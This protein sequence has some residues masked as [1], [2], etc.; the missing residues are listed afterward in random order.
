[1]YRKLTLLL[2]ALV[3]LTLQAQEYRSASNTYYW[4]NRK[5]YEGYWQQ[6]VHYRIKASLNDSTDII[7]GQQQLTYWN[8]SP[9]ELPFVYFRLTQNAFQPDSYLDDLQKNNKVKPK[10]GVYE[11]MRLGTTIESLMV[12]GKVLRT[13]LDNTIL[14]VYLD[15]PLRSGESITFDITFKTYFDKGNTRRRMKLFNSYGYKHYD[16]V[17]WYP[18]ISVYD[19]KFG[20]TTDQHLGRE[21]YG[22]FG[23]FDVE[24]TLPNH[25]VLDATGVLQ[26]RSEVM[27]DSLRQKLDIKNFAKKPLYERPS[28]IIKR[29]GTRKTWKFYADNVHDFAFTADPTYRIGETEWNGIKC[30]S[31][32]QEPHA[33][34]WQ[35]AADYTARILKVY[36]EDIG[37]YAY[38][39]M[40][41]ADAQDGM[42][43]PMLTLDGGF[44][45]GYRSLLAHEVGH[46]WFFGMVGNNETYRAALDEG[47]TQFLT[48]WCMEKLEGPYEPVVTDTTFF[49]W[50]INR[51]SKV[52]PIRERRAYL[53]YLNDAVKDLDMP[54]NTHS[55]QFNGALEHGGGYRHVYYK[56]A[57]MLYNLQYVLGDELFLK[58]MQHYFNQWKMCHPYFE[59][60]R[61][62]IIQYTHV[63]LNWFFDQW[64]E[65]TKH[66]DYRVKSVRKGTKDG[67]FVITFERKGDMQMPLDFQVIDDKDRRHEFHIPNDWFVKKT[68]A[69][70]LPRWIGWGSVQPEYQATV[71]IPEGIENVVIDTTYRLA[72]VNMLNNSRRTPYTLSFDS[73]MVNSP[74][75]TQ[76]EFK[77]RPDIWY[78]SYDGIKAGVHVNGGYMN[79]KHVFSATL[80]FNT[81]LAQ[82]YLSPEVRVNRFDN[83]SYNLT[84]SNGIHEL[85]RNTFLKL[86]AR[87]L[88]GLNAYTAGITKSDLSQKNTL[89]VYFKSMYRQDS[90]DLVYLLY[91]REWIPG[92]YNNTINVGVERKYNYR[93]GNGII[94]LGLKSS[95]LGSSYDYARISLTVVNRNTLGKFDLHTRT[96]A[97]YGTGRFLPRESAL[98]LA[99]GNPEDLMENK[100]TRSRGFIDNSYLGYGSGLNHFQSGGGLNLRGYAGYLVAH[101]D[102]NKDI[103]PVYKG[104]S[105]ASVSAE[106]EFDRLFRFRPAL[107]RRWL[108][109]DTYLFA[110]AGVISSN[111]PSE[112]FALSDLR[113]DAGIGTAFTIKRWGPLEAVKP[114][115][116]RFDF[117]LFL[118]RP[119]AL[120][121]QF[122]KFRWVMGISR[123]F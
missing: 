100:F 80:W 65:T 31:L 24:L 58:A 33:S 78:N 107:F 85:S 95:T 35:N 6:D 118:S 97:Q 36:S 55:D 79:Y 34:R 9:D 41:V 106:L 91:P 122:L 45:P 21:F 1:M 37:M 38:P 20:W 73:R 63:D 93:N 96:Y 12:N 102:G 39:K 84:Y 116:V 83:V 4:K 49:G 43:Y 69:T 59:D 18:R 16:G 64:M 111:G 90:T 108:K 115:T 82:S 101:L 2:T 30:I 68:S 71:N 112:D 32:V 75:R 5:P 60:F 26:N 47:F 57:T 86:S 77:A 10:Y 74:D 50:Y 114:L 110:D 28:V 25:F 23:T 70:V 52:A 109:L 42:E 56:T 120:E 46:N 121:D 19:R 81:G 40:I 99:G 67:E 17:H 117:P 104:A 76:Y 13:E 98:Y 89:Y 61:N 8:N 113:S 103:V 92:L 105:G 27:P 87:S 15:Q 14:K 66:I 119:P 53:A 48:S 7:D 88:D 3:H 11:G 51:Y 123:T 54:L 22:D 72:D 44:D 94:D 29:N 62:S